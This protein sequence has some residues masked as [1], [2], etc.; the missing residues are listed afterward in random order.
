[1]LCGKSNA[2]KLN[3]KL[4]AGKMIIH[5]WPTIRKVNLK[6]E[7]MNDSVQ[8]RPTPNEIWVGNGPSVKIV[9]EMLL[10][11]GE[12]YNYDIWLNGVKIHSAV[13]GTSEEADESPKA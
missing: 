3:R 9:E 12:D 10:A 1:L 4:G 6:E 2:Q 7:V 11:I 5:S 8:T 13:V